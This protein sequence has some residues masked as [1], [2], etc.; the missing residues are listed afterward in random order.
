MKTRN[1]FPN[2]KS[3]NVVD[4]IKC[5][6][7]QVRLRHNICLVAWDMCTSFGMIWNYFKLTPWV[8]YWC[9]VIDGMA[10]LH[11]LHD[12]DVHV[13]ERALYWNLIHNSLCLCR[14]KPR[15][16]R[17]EGPCPI[18]LHGGLG[19]VQKLKPRFVQQV[20][21]ISLMLSR[22]KKIVVTS[23]DLIKF[24]A[25]AELFWETTNTI[26]FLNVG[27]VTLYLM[28]SH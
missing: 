9:D 25:L 20:L 12:H 1:L 14:S 24:S 8:M 15:F 5:N 13:I 28:T 27:K 2:D 18:P 23:K 4:V 21:D 10:C 7:L 17:I 3:C 22:W 6:T 19:L 26:H 11:Q 16:A